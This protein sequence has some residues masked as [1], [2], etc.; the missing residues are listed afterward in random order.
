M[1]KRELY[2]VIHAKNPDHGT[3]QALAALKAGADGVALID[4]FCDTADVSRIA[5]R[6]REAVPQVPLLLNF[7]DDNAGAA[8]AATWVGCGVWWDDFDLKTDGPLLERCLEAKLPVLG[9]IAFKYRREP[10][11]VS[12]WKLGHA[13]RL[14]GMGPFVPMTTGFWT[15]EPPDQ[16][17][18]VLFR[19]LLGPD[20]PLAVAS[21]VTSDNIGWMLPLATHFL[22]GTSIERKDPATMSAVVVPELVADL[23][24][25]V[26]E[27]NQGLGAPE[28]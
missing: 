4:Q 11:I 28:R 22:V 7:L 18:V 6:V 3:E 24:A 15:G 21:G 27:F 1:T 20:L 14:A 13:P 23:A 26:R 8:Q 5:R 25:R 10:E 9:G 2:A 19:E 12:G 16:R 17:K